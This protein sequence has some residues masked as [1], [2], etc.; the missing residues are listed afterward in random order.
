M[1]SKKVIQSVLEKTKLPSVHISVTDKPATCI[2]SKFGG[3]FYLPHGENIP[4]CPEGEQI[5]FLAQINFSKMPHIED[6]P[7]KDCFISFWIQMKHVLRKK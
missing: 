5:Q 1:R 4:T 2:D 6:F 3:I 7:E